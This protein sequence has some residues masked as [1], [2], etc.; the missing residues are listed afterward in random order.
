MR[1]LILLFL[2]CLHTGQ[3]F[4]VSPQD[5]IDIVLVCLSKGKRVVE[6]DPVEE[7]IILI[8]SV[9][10]FNKQ[11]NITFNILVDKYSE[12][13]IRRQLSGL[14]EPRMPRPERRS[15]S[16]ENC[17]TRKEM[18]EISDEIIR[19]GVHFNFKHLDRTWL[20]QKKKEEVILSTAHHSGDAGFACSFF[21]EIFPDLD[22]IIFLDSDVFLVS[23]VFEMWSLFDTWGPSTAFSMAYN[24][25][26]NPKLIR[27]LVYNFGVQLISLR[28]MQEVK[29]QVPLALLQ[30]REDETKSGNK[31]YVGQMWSNALAFFYP[32]FFKRLSQKWNLQMCAQLNN[33]P[34][35]WDKKTI[36]RPVG[37]VHYNCVGHQG[38]NSKAVF[39]R[40]LD[41]TRNFIEQAPFDLLL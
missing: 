39:N 24:N 13:L 23:D 14:L 34:A 5:T 29:K 2:F 28:R 41:G 36:T 25:P 3:S 30:E 11:N 9:L 20:K 37:A 15:T 10:L 32:Q 31:L 22:R 4:S 38:R 16:I 1:L 40:A 26:P 21:E 27:F 17:T 19:S 35:F 33:D 6:E 7:I 18:C 8:K 12:M